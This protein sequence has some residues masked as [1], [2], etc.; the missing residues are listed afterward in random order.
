MQREALEQ[1][2]LGYERAPSRQRRR[3]AEGD[4]EQRQMTECQHATG[5]RRRERDDRRRG[6]PLSDLEHQQ[7]S[8]AVAD[9]RRTVECNRGGCHVGDVVAQAPRAHV[10]IRMAVWSTE[11]HRPAVPPSGGEVADP[12]IPDPGAA[13][14]AV[15][16]EYSALAGATYWP[17]MDR[18][19]TGE[20][21]CLGRDPV[22]HTPT[23]VATP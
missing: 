5:Q 6:R 18:V 3:A 16:E 13:E 20:N 11:G 8:Q 14:H 12:V 10:P 2:A 17:R 21:P 19:Q 15:H 1:S 7:P 23:P 4:T 22:A 9:E